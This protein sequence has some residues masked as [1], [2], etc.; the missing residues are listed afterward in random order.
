MPYISYEDIRRQEKISALIDDTRKTDPK[1][2]GSRRYKSMRSIFQHHR[3]ERTKAAMRDK[4]VLDDG[5]ES[6]TRA[7]LNYKYLSH[8]LPLHPRR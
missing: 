4:V 5:L 3:R 8:D 7:Y 1:Y 2:L 6:A